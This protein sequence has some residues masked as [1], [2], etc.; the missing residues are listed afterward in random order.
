MN[1]A[2]QL[3]YQDSIIF[4]LELNRVMNDLVV[5]SKSHFITTLV[6]PYLVETSGY[7]TVSII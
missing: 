6:S 7:S 4:P 5:L 3:E 1:G 2:L